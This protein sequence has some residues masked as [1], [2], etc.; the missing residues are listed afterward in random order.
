MNPVD[1]LLCFFLFYILMIV[2]WPRLWRF[3]P[4]ITI[5]LGE[6]AHCR[7][8]SKGFFTMGYLF[9]IDRLEILPYLHLLV[10][11]GDL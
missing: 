10:Y 5:A 2:G 9:P 4:A 1:K 11:I 8:N 6:D 7:F 3:Y